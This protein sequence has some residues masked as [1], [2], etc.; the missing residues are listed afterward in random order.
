MALTLTHNL[1]L[2][3]VCIIR[4]EEEVADPEYVQ[5]SDFGC[6]TGLTFSLCPE[7]KVAHQW[8]SRSPWHR[9]L[10]NTPSNTARTM[11]EAALDQQC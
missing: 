1:T 2:Q 6:S 7:G 4:R 9:G 11:E 5:D 10:D 8:L 3:G